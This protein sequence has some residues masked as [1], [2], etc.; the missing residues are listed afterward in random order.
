MK[1]FIKR[2][3]VLIKNRTK[4]VKL[5]SG[6]NIDLRSRFE[7]HNYIG[8]NVSFTGKIGYGSYIG[9]DSNISAEIGKYTSISTNVN[10]VN[11]LH[12]TETFVSTH[13]AFY[14]KKNS[15][16]LS[17]CKENKFDENK[18]ANEQKKLSV[19]IGNDV[20]IGWGATL[21][22]GV[23]VGDGAIVAAGAIVTKDVPP[24]AIVGG[25]P[26]KLI[27][28]R[29]DEEERNKLLSL[30]WWNKDEEWI[31]ANA[32]D[33]CDINNIDKLCQSK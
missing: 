15:V 28:F 27:R 24:Y 30:E 14:S 23:T 9:S 8:R 17:Y 26:A 25:V 33:L 5:C 22:A 13:S 3:L 19:V 32:E 6:A 1:K 7:G 2:I 21:L 12:P 16:D 18:Y 4:S 11:G 20:W 10:V 31:K 29:F